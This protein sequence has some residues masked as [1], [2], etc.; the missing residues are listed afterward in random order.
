MTLLEKLKYRLSRKAAARV[1]I[2]HPVLGPLSWSKAEKAWLSDPAFRDLGFI[3]QISGS[4][5][6]NAAL[7]R[8]AVKIATKKTDLFRRIQRLLAVDA[9]TRVRF[10]KLR[11]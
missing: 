9:A 11:N 5:Q 10:R 2:D 3:F 4:P 6:P 7:V 1:T 8:H